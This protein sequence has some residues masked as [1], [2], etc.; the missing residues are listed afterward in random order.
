M[1]EIECPYCETEFELD[2]SGDAYNDQDGY[3]EAE[4]PNCGKH[5]MVTTTWMPHREAS[6][7]DCLNGAPHQMKSSYTVPRE[8]SKMKCK[9]CDHQ[10]PCTPKEIERIKN[11]E[12]IEIEE[13]SE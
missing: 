5:F 2:C 13:A 7:A 1:D 8:Y 11:G 9:N 4:C 10:R 3:D 12:I 6:K